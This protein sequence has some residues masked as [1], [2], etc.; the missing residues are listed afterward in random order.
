MFVPSS[1]DAGQ[2]EVLRDLTVLGDKSFVSA[3]LIQ[4]LA[5]NNNIN[6]MTLPKSNQKKKTTE[7]HVRQTFD[8]LNR[9]EELNTR[10]VA[11]ILNLPITAASIRLKGLADLGLALRTEIRDNQGKQFILS[12]RLSYCRQVRAEFKVFLP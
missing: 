7:E 9:H 5:H 3:P 6:L 12:T 1:P 11:D 4:E 2:R 10:Q 8:L